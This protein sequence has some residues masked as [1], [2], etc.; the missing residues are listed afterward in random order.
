[1]EKKVW[2]EAD[3]EAIRR[4]VEIIFE[5]EP[6]EL[7]ADMPISNFFERFKDSVTPYSFRVGKLLSVLGER[8]SMPVKDDSIDWVRL[9]VAYLEDL[10]L[11]RVAPADPAADPAPIIPPDPDPAPVIDTPAPAKV[12]PRLQ[13]LKR[14]EPEPTPTAAGDRPYLDTQELADM[15]KMSVKFIVK[16]R[17]RMAG[18]V[19]IGRRWRFSRVAVEKAL[20]CG[21]LVKA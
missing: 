1:M 5:T 21:N 6:G 7:K 10:F 11:Q 15:L 19:R 16:N 12:K 2:T 4:A 17:P 18:A 3:A 20:L 13:L 9:S 14:A 8:F